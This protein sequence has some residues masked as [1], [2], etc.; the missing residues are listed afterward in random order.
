VKLFEGSG[1]YA[2]G[3][4]R[5]D[6]ISVE[7]VVRVNLFFLDHP[8]RSGIFNVGTGA[9]QSFNDV[10]IATV[11]TCAAANGDAARTLPELQAAGAIRYI[12]FPEDL[13][14]K[15]QNYT[16]ADT[17]ALRA[18]GYEAPFLTVEQ[19][20]TRYCEELLRSNAQ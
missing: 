18:A 13:K 14:G 6:F 3:E 11:N 9:A 4:Q 8:D 15:Y 10:A 7:D 12:P 2:D 17:T 1:G 5:R 16:Q 20:V 19:G